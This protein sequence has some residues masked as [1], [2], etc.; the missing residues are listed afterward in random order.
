MCVYVCV[1]IYIYF[2][3][4]LA[5]SAERAEK[6]YFSS[7]GYWFLILFFNQK[8]QDSLEKWLIL[9]K[10]SVLCIPYVWISFQRVVYIKGDSGET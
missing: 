4:F 3:F 10:E 2:F 7:N 8:N 5:L 9:R 6:Q 1:Y